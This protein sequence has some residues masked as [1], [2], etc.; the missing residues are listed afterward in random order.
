[1]RIV[2]TAL[3]LSLAIAFGA[4]AQQPPPVHEME[5]MPRGPAGPPSC[6]GCDLR[7]AKL[8]KKDYTNA[9]FSGANLANADLRELTLD[10]ADFGGADLTG[11]K[12]DGIQ[13]SGCNFTRA[14]LTDATFTGAKLSGADLQ[15]ARVDGTHFGSIDVSTLTHSPVLQA[16]RNETWACGYA[17]LSGLTSRIHVSPEGKDTD[18]CGSSPADTCATIAKGIARCAASGCGVLVAWGEYSPAGAIALRDG[19]NVYGGCFASSRARKEY[20]SAVH[21][22]K[23]QPAFTS[24]VKTKT[25]LQGFDIIGADGKSNDGADTVALTVINSNQTHVLHSRVTAGLGA[26]GAK[27]ADGI[28][29]AKGGNAD[30]RDGG[31]NS[32][33]GNA[34]GGSGSP[35]VTVSVGNGKCSP[36]YT[37]NGYGYGGEMGSTGFSASGGSPGQHVCAYCVIRWGDD[38]GGGGGGRNAGCGGAGEKS[39][40]PEGRFDGVT[41]VGISGGDGGAGGVG[42][43]GGGGGAGGYKAGVCFA[44]ATEAGNRGGGGGAGGCGGGI[45]RGGQQG[46]G[47][48]GIVLVNSTL[49]L[50]DTRV[51][52]GRG[53]NGGNGGNGAKGGWPGAGTGGGSSH[54]TGRGGAGGGGGAGGASGGG[55]GGNSGPSVAVVTINSTLNE[56]RANYLLGA[57]GAPGIHGTGGGALIGGLCSAPN[58]QDGVPG[59]VA[60]KRGY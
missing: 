20:V 43:G 23:G 10:G 38:G 17:D 35:D 4:A 53:G 19:V 7:S 52:G 51:I 31:R 25:I 16:P 47:S 40:R 50:V 2:R 11:A 39:T 34:N 29:G 26:N 37:N 30:G 27:G 32:G 1:M 44:D 9:N 57:T 59:P 15:F 21:G 12:L 56:T 54:S 22:P 8:E 49:T 14:I 46:G 36:S 60:V 13:C 6:P 24:S 18:T 58:G 3:V 42:G 45:G 5:S 41:W 55:A 48:F 28:D 33:C